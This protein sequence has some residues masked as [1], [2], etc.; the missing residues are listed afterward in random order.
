MPMPKLADYNTAVQNPR[1]CFTDPELQK[2]QVET[3][4]LG[5][6]RARSGGFAITYRLFRSSQEW[7]VR[8]F[9]REVPELQRKYSA[10]SA[11]LRQRPSPLF[12]PFE[13]EPQG[14]RVGGNLYP[15]VKMGWVKGQTLGTFIENELGHSAVLDTL[16]ETFRR[17]VLYLEQAGMAH[18]DLQHGNVMVLPDKSIRFIDYDG[19][20][21][22]GMQLGQG[23]EKGHVNYQHPARDAQHF[24][25]NMDR[26]SAICIYVSLKALS[27]RAEL[28]RRYNT[29]ENMIFSAADFAN[30]DVSPVFAEL[31]TVPGVRDYAERFRSVCRFRIEDIPSLEDFIQGKLP[32]H[33][34]IITAPLRVRRQYPLVDAT[35]R[36]LLLQL[37]GQVV[38]VVG[39]ISDIH[40]DITRFGDPYVF[41]NFGDWK[42]GCFYLVLWSGALDKLQQSGTPFTMLSEH[43]VGKWVSVTGL[44][45]TY[46]SKRR[47]LSP[48][49][50]VENPTSIRFLTEREAKDLLK[51]TGSYE[52]QSAQGRGGSVP[53]PGMAGGRIRTG[54][55]KEKLR[56]LLGHEATWAAARSGSTRSRKSTPQPQPVLSSAQPSG[57]RSIQAASQKTRP[58]NREF[59]EGQFGRTQS[60]P[61][62]RMQPSPQRT[63]SQGTGTGPS[64]ECFIATAAYGSADEQHVVVL[65]CWRDTVLRQTRHGRLLIRVYERVSPPIARWVARSERRRQVVRWLLR[66]L[67]SRVMNCIGS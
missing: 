8:C 56:E 5:L 13:Y 28:W 55:N 50:V 46:A 54:D 39:M 19:M 38:E 27:V 33:P 67:V 1:T 12:E 41:L 42:T 11:Y 34:V 60:T 16:A 59:L 45:E 37:E 3:T 40:F 53:A 62:A 30:P 7:A 18:G 20:Y 32:T 47:K 51:H 43:F 65:R 23:H 36:T 25:P 66:W 35:N 61:T 21:V 26:F 31:V 24:G 2:C 9:H 17:A 14:I 63:L 22:P 49:M 10:I 44:I 58:S 64:G 52:G 4:P 6:P 57:K 48:Q 29:Q 15:I